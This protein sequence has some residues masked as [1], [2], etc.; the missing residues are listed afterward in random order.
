[1]SSLQESPFELTLT[2]AAQRLNVHPTTLRRWADNGDIP[3]RITPG[4]HRRF[5]LADIEQFT[6]QQSRLRPTTPLAQMWAQ[7]VMTQTRHEL[8]GQ[9]HQ[10]W[11]SGLNDDLRERHRLLGRQLM[12]LTLQ[13][14]SEPEENLTLLQEAHQVGLQYGRIAHSLSLP[15]TNALQAAIFFRDT[16]TEVAFQLPEN[17]AIK[18]EANLRLMRRINKLLNTVHLAIAQVYDEAHQP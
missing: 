8:V 7:Q 5:A 3:Y 6:H 17:T 16:L 14:I 12:G 1:M 9:G 18:P 15:L 10:P 11:L 2:Q 13:F 4:N